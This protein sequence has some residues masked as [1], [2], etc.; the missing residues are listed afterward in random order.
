VTGNRLENS[1]NGPA[2]P[3]RRF[4]P[5]GAIGALAAV[6]ETGGQPLRLVLRYQRESLG[7]GEVWRLVT[8][9][10]VHLGA[11]H[12]L[13][14]VLALGVLA[15][16]FRRLLCD[17]DWWLGC[18]AAALAIDAGLYFGNPAVQ[19]YVGLSGVLHGVWAI[20]AVRAWQ[21]GR[22]EA[23]AFALL[24]AVK[25]GYEALVGPVPLTGAVAAGPVV[26]V[27]HAYGAAGGAAYALVGFAVRTRS[28]P[29]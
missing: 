16:I 24:L 18:L 23:V 11:S 5:P 26:A 28:R 13:M 20:A 8:G 22:G 15:T 9:H 7:G 10:L 2:A 19:W 6:A 27:A 3:L 14:N 29:L 21:Q 17:R 12:M 4:L 1:G 25:L